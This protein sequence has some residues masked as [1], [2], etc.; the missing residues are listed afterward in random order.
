MIEITSAAQEYFRKLISQQ[1][2]EGLGLRISVSHAGTPGASCDL[3][4]CPQ[5]QNMPD[6]VVREFDGFNLFVAEASEKWLEKA[7]I[8]FE[9][10]PTGGQLTIKAPGIKGDEPGQDAAL[11]D[12]VSWLLQTEINPAL[13]SHGGRVALV[14]I[15][16]AKEV[17]LQFGGGCQGCGMA[18]VTMK[19]GIEQTLKRHIPEI[20]AVKD[21]TDHDSGT[22]P[23]YASSSEGQSAV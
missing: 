16:D 18:D 22:N 5:G 7:E 10:D 17:I 1:D 20:T 6:D 15:T 9:E 19:Q 3:Q 21:V 23:Y 14:E 8:D 13:A 4:F 11:E 2:D 12:R